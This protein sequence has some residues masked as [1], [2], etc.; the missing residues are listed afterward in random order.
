MHHPFSKKPD[1][2]DASTEGIH[3]ITRP[4]TFSDLEREF[5]NGFGTAFKV[6]L[7]EF[8]TTLNFSFDRQSLATNLPGV[9]SVD[10]E[11]QRGG[12]YRTLTPDTIQDGRDRY[13]AVDLSFGV[14]VVSRGGASALLVRAVRAGRIE[15][16]CVFFPV[17]G[18]SF[19]GPCGAGACGRHP[20][21]DSYPESAK[22]LECLPN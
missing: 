1:M 16:A 11:R 7:I 13:L 10:P 5:G 18:L 9:S 20:L 12:L 17:E 15:S 4:F 21:C 14:P 6:F 2:K 3:G 22:E 8:M 19:V